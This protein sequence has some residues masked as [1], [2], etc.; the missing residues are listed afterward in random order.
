MNFPSVLYKTVKTYY[1]YVSLSCETI[2]LEHYKPVEPVEHFVIMNKPIVMNCQLDDGDCPAL[3]VNL[4]TKLLYRLAMASIL[5][6]IISPKP[7]ALGSILLGSWAYGAAAGARQL[8][9]EVGGLLIAVQAFG[10]IVVVIS[11][12]SCDLIFRLHLSPGYILTWLRMGRSLE[13]SQ[14]SSGVM[15]FP[16]KGRF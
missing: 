11:K 3:T 13:G 10:T 14:W 16:S 9:A 2:I 5:G 7:A 4:E 6:R 12:D 1:K 15:S 8:S